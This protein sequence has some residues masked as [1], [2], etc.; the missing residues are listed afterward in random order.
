MTI[1]K[2]VSRLAIA[3][4]GRRMSIPVPDTTKRARIVHQIVG[5]TSSLHLRPVPSGWVIVSIGRGLDLAAS[6]GKLRRAAVRRGYE[7]EAGF[8]TE[9]WN[10]IVAGMMKS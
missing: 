4:P 9:D 7:V 8:V 6:V 10:P 1:D 2:Q 5:P 3:G